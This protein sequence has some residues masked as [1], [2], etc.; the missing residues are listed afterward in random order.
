MATADDGAAAAAAAAAELLSG[1]RHHGCA[2]GARVLAVQRARVCIYVPG[3]GVRYSNLSRCFAERAQCDAATAAA[4]VAVAAEAAAAAQAKAAQAA[5][6]AA[7]TPPAAV[8]PAAAAPAAAMA[9]QQ[10]QQQQQQQASPGDLIQDD[11]VSEGVFGSQEAVYEGAAR[12]AVVACLN[13]FGACLLCYGQT[14]SGKTHTIFGPDGVLEQVEDAMG[15]GKA[16]GKAAGKASYEQLPKSCGVALRSIA[17][18]LCALGLDGGAGGAAAGGE[19]APLASAPT[20]GAGGVRATVTL[21]Y[22]EL[23]QGKFT[24]LESGRPVL[25]RDT[26]S[27][28]HARAAAPA[29]ADGSSSDVPA[30]QFMLQGASEVRVAS[31]SDAIALLQRGQARKTFAATAMNGRSSRAH[32]ILA[33][34]VAQA[35]PVGGGSAGGGADGGGSSGSG[36]GGAGGGGIGG[37]GGDHVVRSQ[38]HLVDLAGSERLKKSKAE[39]RR[40]DEAI[41]INSS[42]MVLGKCIAALVGEKA[43]VPY[44][45]SRLTM[46]LKSAFGGN[47]R[48]TAIICASMA[49]AHGAETLNAMR[50]GERCSMITNAASTSAHINAA[51][52]VATIGASLATCEAQLG[53]LAARGKSQLPSYAKLKQRYL[54]LKQKQAELRELCGRACT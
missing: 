41:G 26:G 29:R 6:A 52:A 34:S 1:S 43:H 37:P 7:A 19:A 14:G 9:Q 32:T 2:V 51:D 3:V 48:T 18:I 40:R 42:L 20:L 33:V 13:G 12:D 23:Y 49:D 46:L 30:A 39:G 11:P 15:G 10:Q 8:A 28:L 50:F 21:Q 47:S 54:A 22:V 53:A 17:E 24:C 31:M 38:L 35:R 16:V 25:L 45:E 44:H 5:Q 4:K 27:T 36:G